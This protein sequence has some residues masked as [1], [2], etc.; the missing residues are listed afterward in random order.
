MGH[1]SSSRLPEVD[2]TNAY[3]RRQIES[4]SVDGDTLAFA[5]VQTG[6]KGRF[7]RAW[8]SPLGG[9]WM[10]IATRLPGDADAQQRVMNGLALRLALAVRQA[11]LEQYT[12][13]GDRICLKWP[14]DLVVVGR[15]PA[16]G[17]AGERDWKKVG[18][19]LIEKFTVDQRHW[20]VIGVGVNANFL[21]QS[22]PEDLRATTTTLLD[23]FT[24]PADLSLLRERLAERLLI[25][26]ST[27]TPI[28]Q[29]VDE[30]KGVMVGLNQRATVTLPNGETLVGTLRGIASASGLA[31]IEF[32]DSTLFTVP[33]GTVIKSA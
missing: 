26:A 24:V 15:V 20:L 23:E 12:D 25:A 13:C 22:L 28:Q 6:G 3:L 16:Q 2:S 18:G 17:R 19:V 27:P 14:N 11:V 8:Q 1:W 21:P 33:H 5:D 7:G 4:G 10:S 32:P 31:E 30:F 9:L 29:V